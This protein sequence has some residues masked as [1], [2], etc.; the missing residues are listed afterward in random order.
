M[1]ALKLLLF[2]LSIETR[3]FF[4]AVTATSIETADLQKRNE[5]FGRMSSI[6]KKKIS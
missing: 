4:F 6:L 3:I 2:D 5:T 1:R